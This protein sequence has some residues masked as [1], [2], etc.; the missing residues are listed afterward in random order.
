[1]VVAN[2]VLIADLHAGCRTGLYP[3]DRALQL[4]DGGDYRPSRLQRKAWAMWR[5]FWDEWVPRVC[6]RG[7]YAVAVVGDLVDGTH[8]KSVHQ[9]SHNP[10][11][12][13]R[14]A[15]ALLGPIVKRCGGR[16]FVVRGTEAHVGPSAH[17][18]EDLAESL[19]AVPDEEGRF[20]RY[21][22]WKLVGPRESRK[23]ALVHAMHHIGTTGSSH[24]E[25]TAV[26]KEL[27]EAFQ[28]SGRWGNRAPDFVVRAHRHRYLHTE[29][30]T[31]HGRAVS[32]VLPG[33]QGKTPFTFRI[34]GGRQSQPQFGGVIIRCG[35]EEWYMRQRVWSLARTGAV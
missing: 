21:E 35:D 33:W 30:A 15:A 3:C 6:R 19:G 34:P 8:H 2:L 29:I 10:V 12:Q 31:E 7:P 23:C 5:E 18:E 17:L 28:E 4:D 32:V 24:Y 27:V 22:L 26:H 11:D 16:F 20:A 25:S 1:M 13:K 9:I 14:I